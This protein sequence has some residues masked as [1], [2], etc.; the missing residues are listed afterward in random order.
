[1][2]GPGDGPRG[3]RPVVAAIDLG[4]LAA[5][6]ALLRNLVA[7]ARL[8]VVVKADGYGHGAV[9]VARTA[10]RAGADY[11]AV[12]LVEEGVELREAGISSPILVLSEPPADAFPVAVMQDLTLT[13]YTPDGLDRA[14]RAAADAGRRVAVH[15]KVDSGMHRVGAD[16]GDVPALAMRV[17]ASPHLL[18]EG[19]FTHLAV[20]DEPGDPFT[21]AQLDCLAAVR[22]ALVEMGISP[23]LVH[24]ANSAAAIGHP[25]A[26]LDLVRCGIACYGHLPSAALGPALA[27]GVPAGSGLRPVLSLSSSV[28][29]V[30]RLPAGERTSYGRRYALAG[31]GY[32]ATVPI[33]YADGVP[34][35]LGEAGGEVLI[36]G[37][38]RRIAGTVTM[39]QLMVDCGPEPDVA[40]GDEVVLIGRQGSAEVTA[41]EWAGLTGTVAY[42]IL[43]RIGPRVPR[44]PTG[45]FPAPPVATASG[46]VASGRLAV[47]Q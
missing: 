32:L 5:N 4:A 22:G 2:S 44:R 46:P 15:L 37:R 42:E 33:G 9:L 41:E 39:D 38:R 18:L 11:F 31:D 8:C 29:L 12:A 17:A 20:A 47:R 7:P 26:R 1:V 25:D 40:P 14:E 28:H 16:P 45:T 23:P 27:A 19:L 21:A 34:R 36:G 43:T 10:E 13:C 30:R 3:T 35:S 24:A 6:V